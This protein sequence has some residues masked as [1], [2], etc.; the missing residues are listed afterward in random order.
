[1]D[2]E[3]LARDAMAGYRLS[4]SAKDRFARALVTQGDM[5]RPLVLG[6]GSVKFASTGKGEM[7]V[8]T[9]ALEK[10]VERMVLRMRPH[11][12]VLRL[13][14]DEFR[15]TLCDSETF[16]PT[17]GKLVRHWTRDE[18]TGTSRVDGMR[19]SHRVR[20][21]T[22]NPHARGSDRDINAA[23]NI[24]LLT[25]YKFYGLQRPWPLSRST[26]KAVFVAR[27]HQLI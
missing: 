21:C 12:A 4:R 6:T 5:R 9:S 20:V 27:A 18:E 10:A 25:I 13:A 23:R 17:E 7:A 26:S 3:F 19:R 8:P 14:I 11:R 24:L 15:T 1:M 22:A 16:G 2:D